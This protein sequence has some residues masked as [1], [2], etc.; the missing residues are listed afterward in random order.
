MTD[1]DH[2]V[3]NNY[4]QRN[5]APDD[6]CKRVGQHGH[7]QLDEGGEQNRCNGSR[8][9]GDKTDDVGLVAAYPV[10][11]LMQQLNSCPDSG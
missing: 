5:N 3:V 4:G 9:H 10:R 7:A 2:Q 6:P 8:Q 11:H 1:V